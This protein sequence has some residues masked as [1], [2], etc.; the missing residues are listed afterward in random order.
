M[1]LKIRKSRKQQHK[2]L[3]SVGNRMGCGEEKKNNYS[4]EEQNQL[5][6]TSPVSSVD[7]HINKSF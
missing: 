7:F 2:V 5:Q 6:F 1:L 4:K 3:C